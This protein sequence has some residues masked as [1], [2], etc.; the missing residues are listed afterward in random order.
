MRIAVTGGAGFIGAN[1]V[2]RLCAM[3]SIEDVIVVDDMSTGS[4]ENLDDHPRLTLLE[5]SI[6]DEA[7]LDDAF[8]GVGAV[9]HLAARPSVPRSIADPVRT[10]DVNA[11]G[12]VHVLEAVRRAGLPHTIVASSSSIYGANPTLPKREDLAP[13]PLSPYAA[14]KLAAEKYALAYQAAYGIDTLALRFFNVF[15]PYQSADHAYAAVIPSFVSAALNRRPLTIHGDGLQT[16]DFTYVGTVVDVLVSALERRVTSPAAV[17]LAFGSRRTL[18][19]VVDAL[20]SLL[21]APVDVRH[22]PPRPG[23]VPHSQASAEH[24]VRL[25]PGIAPTDFHAALQRTVHWFRET[26]TP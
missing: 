12:T 15:G 8:L 6:L 25:F 2:R 9:V 24:L 13:E 7:L 26:A 21:Q 18:L 20:E 17:N 23:D 16:R 10:H 19:E 5:G 4:R 3:P 1:L 14:S 11:T 22:V